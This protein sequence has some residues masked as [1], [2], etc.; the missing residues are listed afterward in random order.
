MWEEEGREDV[1]RE[2]GREVV[3]IEDRA[4]T[5]GVVPTPAM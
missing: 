1:G 3:S 5:R 2:E 4:H